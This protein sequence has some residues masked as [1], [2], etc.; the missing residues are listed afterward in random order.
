MKTRNLMIV[1]LIVE[2]ALVLI[3]LL[4]KQDVWFGIICFWAVLLMKNISDY[5]DNRG[6][7]P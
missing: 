6:K 7:R 5:F 1:L 2:S 4:F 3:G